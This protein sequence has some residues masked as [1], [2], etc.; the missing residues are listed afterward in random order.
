VITLHVICSAP[1][2][3]EGEIKENCVQEVE[4]WVPRQYVERSVVSG[5]SEDEHMEGGCHENVMI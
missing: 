5:L 4:R 1:L 3:D 2:D